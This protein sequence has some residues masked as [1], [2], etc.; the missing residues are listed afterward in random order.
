MET[1]PKLNRTIKPAFK[2]ILKKAVSITALITTFFD[3]SYV[4][5]NLRQKNVSIYNVLKTSCLLS[6]FIKYAVFKS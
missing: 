3:V 4:F 5:H 1:Y 2:P 6:L